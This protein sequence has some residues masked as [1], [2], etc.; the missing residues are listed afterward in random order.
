M[1]VVSPSVFTEKILLNCVS[2]T[3]EF[4]VRLKHSDTP[5]QKAN[6]PYCRTWNYIKNP[7]NSI[8][9]KQESHTSEL[10]SS[11]NYSYLFETPSESNKYVD[12]ENYTQNT[13]APYKEMDFDSLELESIEFSNPPYSSNQDLHETSSAQFKKV[14]HYREKKQVLKK[15]L[16]PSFSFEWPQLGFLFYFKSFI[17]TIILSFL[18]L[19]GLYITSYFFPS[20]YINQNPEKYFERLIGNLP[21]RIVD[22]NGELIAELFSVKMSNL[23][24]NDIPIEIKSLLLF[25]EDQDFYHHNGVDLT[26]IFRALYN[27]II[28]FGYKQGGST[29]TQQLARTLL[30]D[31]N[32]NIGRKLRELALA[33]ALEKKFSKE[34]ILTSYLNFVYM[35]HGNYGIQN[36]AQFYFQ[37]EVSDLNFIENL[38][39]VSLPSAPERYS[40][41][42]NPQLLRNKMDAIIERMKEVHFPLP[43]NYIEMRKNVFSEFGTPQQNIG[44]IRIDKAPYIREYVRQKIGD[45]LGNEYM[46][47]AGLTI[48][49]SLDMNLQRAS[50]IESKNFIKE[51]LERYPPT[52]YKN[53][54]PIKDNKNIAYNEEA[55]KISLP[56]ELLGGNSLS[57]PKPHLQTASIGIENKTGNVVFFQGGTEFGTSNQL[58]RA[59]QMRRQTGSSIKPIVYSLAIQ[60]GI[61]TTATILD[62]KPI[63]QVSRN[64]KSKKYWT[65]SNFNGIY[66]GAISVRRALGFSKNIP[67]IQVGKMLGINNL[68][69]GFND[70]FYTNIEEQEK[71]FRPDDTIAIGSLEMS[72]LEM[73]LAYSAFANNGFIQ[74]PQLILSVQ[75]S[76]GRTL[77]TSKENDEFHLQAPERRKV[78]SGDTAEI[79]VDLLRGGAVQHSGVWKG[80][81]SKTQFV[82]KTGT[83][84][85]F[86]DAWF[87]GVTPEVTT[88]VWV[89][90]DNPMYSMPNGV[91]AELA[92]PLWGRIMKH[93][94]LNSKEKFEFQPRAKSI[95]ICPETGEPYNDTCPSQAQRELFLNKGPFP[96]VKKESSN[97][98]NNDKENEKETPVKKLKNPLMQGIEEY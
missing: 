80:G 72:P 79:L 62:D 52:I 34:E 73:A 44:Q 25:I 9:E 36:A 86:K 67:A 10:D 84:N 41:Y 61:L 32:K 89:G 6:C 55:E 4:Y 26:S 8:K 66:E 68:R 39:L 60:K 45:L 69:N 31:R 35:G 21:N 28:S 92:G 18:V 50:I 85:D 82:G 98:S 74:R 2:C 3:K 53:R 54:R 47:N 88:A 13:P 17:A 33:F 37:K 87:V 30:L 16:I 22:R 20:W 1:S 76:L 43:S 70:F 93:A 23:K 49:T 46:L 78:I 11:S 40:P 96:K 91:G 63:I 27:N 64:G 58:N 57:I 42:R 12:N 77:Y 81:F 95:Y 51:N 75:D 65:P 90:F 19:V 48:K 7:I 97:S 83:S 59:I 15:I 71:R 38:I 14:K 94:N 5:Y 56:I 29:I 24:A